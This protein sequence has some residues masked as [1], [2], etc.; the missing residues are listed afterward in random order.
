MSRLILAYIAQ[1]QGSVTVLI[2]NMSK[3]GGC[4]LC[5]TAVG[6]KDIPWCDRPLWLDPRAGLALPG[7]GGFTPGYV[8]LAPLAHR[9]NLRESAAAVGDVFTRFIQEAILFLEER[10]GPLTFWEHGSPINSTV[11]R[12]ACIE[13]AHMHVAPGSLDLSEPPRAER[14]S[15]LSDA[16]TAETSLPP[17]D[18]Y[19]LLGRT[20]HEVVVG[21]D[22]LVSQF[23]RREWARLLGRGDEWDYLV[24]EDPLITAATIELILGGKG[25]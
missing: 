19:L 7:I 24:A 11:R 5:S 12:S 10:M 14:F 16:L 8:L 22:V 17:G 21:A 15:T 23:Y 4:F 2:S 1:V 9:V 20:S 6:V 18:G 25:V 3:A 13:H